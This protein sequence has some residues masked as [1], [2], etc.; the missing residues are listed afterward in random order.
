MNAATPE[1]RRVALVHNASAY[2]GP[3]MCRWLAAHGHDLVVAE[4]AVGLVD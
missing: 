3:A 1:G 4:P 2:V